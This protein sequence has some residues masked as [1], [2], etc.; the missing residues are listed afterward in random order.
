MMVSSKKKTAIITHKGEIKVE[1]FDKGLEDPMERNAT[2]IEE[3]HKRHVAVVS[4]DRKKFRKS[5]T[6]CKYLY[7][8]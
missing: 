5:V 1:E 8:L 3:I 2:S 4:T 7:I 6:F